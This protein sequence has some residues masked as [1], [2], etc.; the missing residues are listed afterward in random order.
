[1]RSS[2]ISTQKEMDTY[3]VANK[4]AKDVLPTASLNWIK[5]FDS[6]SLT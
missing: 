5:L 2:F 6:F 4:Y 1:M 3:G